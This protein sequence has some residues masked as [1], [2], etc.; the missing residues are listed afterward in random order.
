MNLRSILTS[1]KGFSLTEVLAS[2]VVLSIIIA[3][4]FSFFSQSVLFSTKN[5]TILAAANEMDLLTYQVKTSNLI[6]EITPSQNCNEP[7][8]LNESQLREIIGL[9]NSVI[10]LNNEQYTPKITI[11][12]EQMENQLGLVRLHIQ[13]LDST[14]EDADIL[15]QIY[16][17]IDLN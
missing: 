14:N 1:A 17:Y 7:T 10:K 4:L 8:I 2:I 11:C 5:E 6:K 13:I 16:D 9:E 12:Q 3:G 15:S